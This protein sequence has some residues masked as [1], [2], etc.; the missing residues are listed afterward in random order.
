M[1]DNGSLVGQRHWTDDAGVEWTRR[2]DS[3]VEPRRIERLLRDPETRVLRVTSTRVE[4]P[5]A[6][7][8]GYWARVG[9]YVRGRVSRVPGEKTSDHFDC[10]VAEFR[11]VSRRVLLVFEEAC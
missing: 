6:E 5:L 1:G 9:P 3:G 2:G 7:R 4:V 11:D 8:D 10:A